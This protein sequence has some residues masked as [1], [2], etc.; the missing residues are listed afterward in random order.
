MTKDEAMK[1]LEAFAPLH[2]FLRRTEKGEGWHDE[3]KLYWAHAERAIT[4]LVIEELE[5]EPEPEPKPEP[6]PAP[7]NE[8]TTRG[9]PLPKMED[10]PADEVGAEVEADAPD[11]VQGDEAATT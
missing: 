5:P 1:V 11:E 10:E 4:A 8:T 3:K 2:R 7:P 9:V 6:P